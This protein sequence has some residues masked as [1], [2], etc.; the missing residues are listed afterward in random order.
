MDV[1]KGIVLCCGWAKGVGSETCKE[2]A[3]DNPSSLA[4]MGCLH[5]REAAIATL[6]NLSIEPMKLD[7]TSAASISKALST[8]HKRH[9]RLEF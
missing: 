1:L 8:V 2:R 6:P 7:V 3:I 4:F 9:G 5:R